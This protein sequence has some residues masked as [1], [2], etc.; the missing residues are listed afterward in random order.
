VATLEELI[1]ES[2]PMVDLRRRVDNLL[3]KVSGLR[4]LPPILIQGETGAGKTTLAR[5]IHRSSARKGGPFIDVNCAEFQEALL[6]SQLFGHERYTFTG[7]GPGRTGLFQAAHRGV[8]FLDEIGEMSVALQAKLLKVLDDG[9]MEV[10]RVGATRREA[11]DVAVM[12]ATHAD[13]RAA[14]KDRRFRQDLYTR[15]AGL[16][17]EIPPLRE[18]GSDVVL[19]AEQFLM[20]ACEQYQLPAKTLGDDALAALQAYPWPGNIREL[21]NVIRRAALEAES[22]TVTA[23]DLGLPADRAATLRPDTGDHARDRLLEMLTRT[24][25]NIT[26]TAAALGTT[27]NTIKERIKR[28]QLQS[29]RP[30][31]VTRPAPEAAITK[32]ATVPAPTPLAPDFT[33]E[34][35]VRTPSPSRVQWTRRRLTLLRIQVRGDSVVPLAITTRVL[36]SVI[37]RVQS[38]GGRLESMSPHAVVAVFG[39]EPDEDAPRRAAYAGLAIVKSHDLETSDERQRDGLSIAVGLHVTQMLL[40]EVGGTVTLDEEAKADA[41]RILGHLTASSGAGVALSDVA[42][43]FLRRRFEVVRHA[44]DGRVAAWL[45]GRVSSDLKFGPTEFLGRQRELSLLEGCLERAGEGHGQVVTIVGEPGIG[46]SRLVHEFVHHLAPEAVTVLRGRCL[47]YGAHAPYHLALDVL[48]DACGIQ[49]TDGPEAVDIKGRV[50]LD[51][52][53][54][55]DVP[56]APYVL[57]LLRPG[58]DPVVIGAAPELVRDRTFEALQ[59][60]VMVQQERQ[61]LVMIIEDLQWIDET[62]EELL[63]ALAD[64]LVRQRFLLVCTSRPGR[65]PPWAGRSHASQIA[66]LPLSAEASE[67]LVVS[68]LG[69]R[70]ADD[71]LVAAILTRGEGNP[72]FLEELVRALRDD[73]AATGLSIPETV[74]DVLSARI[75]RLSGDERQILQLAAVIGRDVPLAL[76]EAVSDLSPGQTRAAVTGLQAAALLYPI[77]VGGDAEYTFSHA[78]TWDVAH[79]LVLE[80]ERRALHA[81]VVTG[82]ERRY[83]TR[84]LDHVERLAEHAERGALWEQAI[85]YNREA[86]HKAVSHSAHRDAVSYFG[87][88]LAVLERMPEG[89]RT[90]QQGI[91]IRLELRSALLPLGD[92][93]RILE[94]LS[95]LE[96]LAE[97]LGDPRRQ[98]LVAA[99]MTGLY[100]TMGQSEL[101][102]RHGERAREIA[103]QSAD[104]TVAILANCYLAGS[105]FFLG[106]YRR[107]IA[108]AQS[109]VDALPRERS[110]ESFGVAIRPAV[111][112]RGFLS[113]SLSETGRFAEA[114]SVAREALDLAEAIGHP[115]TVAAGLLAMGTF[116]VLRGDIEP[117]VAPLERAHELC[118]RRDIPMWRPTVA[119]FLG[120][121]L[122]LSERFEEGEVL[123]REALDQA[124]LMRMSVFYSQMT[125]WLGEARLLA[126][127]TKEAEEL[128]NAALEAARGRHEAGIEGWGLRLAAEATAHRT[129]LDV[130]RAEGLYRE[131]MERAQACGL[132][133]LTARC[134]LDLGL[135][136]RRAGRS[137]EANDHL[138]A[139]AALFR[140]MQMHGWSERADAELARR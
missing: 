9:A 80:E 121:S 54:S 37:E 90:L 119:S 65:Q 10:R 50:L 36:Q 100:F 124:G 38:F 73:D 138:K 51:R 43:Q 99:L 26:R 53:G 97:Q 2:A 134:H 18:R 32:A 69:D 61:P 111:F 70:S 106:D 19:L 62:S 123:I 112:A 77:R 89:P 12:A 129:P 57:N 84:L 105:Y 30:A 113:W 63:A 87:R 115:P 34:D 125:M 136:Y 5:L 14:V 49:D 52:M 40:A 82:I 131:A 93:P 95:E 60:L 118:R 58:R 13:L 68:T 23:P 78:L 81:R 139:A 128:A 20:R 103:A 98:G 16:T 29:P 130:P 96:F 127:A 74:H 107:S 132:R 6:E 11:V 1:G 85:H 55:A 140:D 31:S 104:A 25:W 59:Q 33:P 28:Y 120:H 86:G 126:G 108:C 44:A 92:F 116:L 79:G 17:L 56:W 122:A 71:E 22:A 45:V 109:V 48:R 24:G 4:E 135:L 42:V 66:L 72:F 114:E 75:F 46:K 27:R 88:A 110:H 15:L 64:A 91:D 76:L 137:H 133:P 8:L 3:R 117:S 102:S 39:L 47:S 83:A 35:D 94:L 67:R 21:I 41:W 7:A 101:A